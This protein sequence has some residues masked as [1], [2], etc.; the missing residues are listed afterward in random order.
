MNSRPQY[1]YQS[2]A[3]KL[4]RQ[5]LTWWVLNS[6]NN[7]VSKSVINLPKFCLSLKKKKRTAQ[8]KEASKYLETSQVSW[9]PKNT[10]PKFC[11][12]TKPKYVTL[13]CL[14]DNGQSN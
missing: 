13:N 12:F 6:A 14:S 2:I 7:E 1:C 5:P 3:I 9:H 8:G 4:G 10:Q 11:I